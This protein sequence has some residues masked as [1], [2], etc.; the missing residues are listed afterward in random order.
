MS[1]VDWA[2]QMITRYRTEKNVEKTGVRRLHYWIISQP[3]EERM[4]PTRGRGK[5]RPFLPKDY[6]RLSELLVDARIDGLIPFDWIV[7]E[8]MSH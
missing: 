6:N 2:V 3:K 8:K 7:D 5:F 4:I 1:Q